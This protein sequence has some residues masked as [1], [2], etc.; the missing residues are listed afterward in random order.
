MPELPEAA[1]KAAVEVDHELV[2]GRGCDGAAGDAPGAVGPAELLGDRRG[3][4]EDGRRGPVTRPGAT[5]CW[6]IDGFDRTRF[7]SV[8]R[9]G[10]WL[11]SR[12][13]LPHVVPLHVSDRW[14]RP[15]NMH[16]PRA[17][18]KDGL[19]GNGNRLHEPAPRL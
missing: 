15:L 19:N 13:V 14:G 12:R 17:S 18:E 6:A 11:E 5:A 3:G 10:L 9:P 2:Q 7:C 16:E 4:A 1:L 8:Y